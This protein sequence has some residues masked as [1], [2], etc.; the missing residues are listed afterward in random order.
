MMDWMSIVEEEESDL[1]VSLKFLSKRVRGG[2]RK[3]K[4]VSKA[5]G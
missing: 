1:L 2:K 3:G 4:G 5:I